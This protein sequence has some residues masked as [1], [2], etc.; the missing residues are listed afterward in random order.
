MPGGRPYRVRRYVPRP[1]RRSYL[2]YLNEDWCPA[3]GGCLRIF[4]DGGLEQAPAGAP[5]SFVDVE[6]RGGTLVR[7]G[8]GGGWRGAA[9][10]EA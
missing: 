3:D 6:P 5:P 10:K 1:P 9:R 2:L 4:T 7:R 8:A